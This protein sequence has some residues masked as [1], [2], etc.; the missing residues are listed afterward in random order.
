M[1][2]FRPQVD[3]MTAYIPGEQPQ[4]AGWIK[5]N[6]NENPYPPSPAVV[7]AIQKAAT[8]RLNMYP[9]PLSTKFR[10]AVAPLFH[11]D[12]D[13]VLP[14]NGSDEVLMMI[15]KTFVDPGEVISF[16]Y[17]SYILYG[18]L[19]EIQ[20]ARFEHLSLNSD[21]SFN[22]TACQPVVDRS[23]IVFVPN[24]NSPSGNR[25]SDDELSSVRPKKGILLVDEAYGDF[26][27][28]PHQGELVRNDA[29]KTT[30]VT[31]TLSKSYS[32]AGIRLGF[33]IAHPDVIAGIRKVKDSYNC[34]TLALAAGTAAITD[35]TYMLQ[36][37]AKI[38]STRQ[39]L[40][41]ALPALG[42]D[43]T[44]SQANFVWTQ[45]E[46]RQHKKIYEL[47]KEQK[48]LVRYMKFDRPES[49]A[50]LGST[51][52]GLRITI[53]TDDEISQFLDILK[54]VVTKL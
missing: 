27:D 2:L 49:E 25:W 52:D 19:A 36:T 30:I 6:T 47:L 46:S 39:R 50:P 12:P 11:V 10:Q 14:G 53:G 42:F 15:L 35:Q 44:P 3:S 40:A 48:I 26:A 5:L 34:D 38:L 24:P 7:D 20:G 13:W 4:T 17:P 33:A 28:T 31:R 9:D 29:S 23:K 1:S 22:T 37:R 8:T 41:D 54:Q 21:W 32:L 45:H 18:T 43:V 16:P 51:R